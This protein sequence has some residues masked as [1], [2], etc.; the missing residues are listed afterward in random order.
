[1]NLTKRIQD[2]YQSMR[3]GMEWRYADILNNA[4]ITQLSDD[5]IIKVVEKE[6]ENCKNWHKTVNLYLK[7]DLGELFRVGKEEGLWIYDTT[8][9]YIINFNLPRNKF[10]EVR[11]AGVELANVFEE[12][13]NK[14]K[15]IKDFM[16]HLKTLFPDANIYTGH[17]RWYE[18]SGNPEY[19]ISIEIKLKEYEY[20]E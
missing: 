6:I 11:M 15:L 16:E 2:A 5:N 7:L 1:M 19:C 8:G 12:T 20:E 14:S 17:C 3:E 18:S 13:L 9:K 10:R 4:I